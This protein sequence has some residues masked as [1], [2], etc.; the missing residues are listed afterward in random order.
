MS[1]PV[2]KKEE[3]KSRGP[4]TLNRK[5]QKNARKYAGTACNVC[6][7]LGFVYDPLGAGKSGGAYDLCECMKKVA[8]ATEPPYHYYDPES[9]SM[10]DCPTRPARDAMDRIRIL[11]RTSGIPDRYRGSFLSPIADSCE[12][13]AALIPVLAAVDH[14]VSSIVAFG[15]NRM[16][17][18]YFHG[19]TGTGKTM[20][21][22]AMLNE[23]IRLYQRHV[24]YAKISRDVLGPLRAS[25]NPNSDLY[26]EGRRIEQEL[27]S[28]PV[29]VIDDFGVQQDTEWAGGVLYDL[30][31]ARYGANLL[32]IFTSNEP[33]DAWKHISKGRLVSRLREMASEIHIDAPDY[34]MR[35]QRTY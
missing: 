16:E 21:A 6:D 27:A 23:I 4:V 26:G 7:G 31:D 30:V 2:I 15:E 33:M 35:S 28:I 32:T 8:R 1:L 24:K 10:L 29:L 5:L 17:G 20:L 9:N 25:F 11:L 19:P 22:C 18:L 3:T 34:R 14:A 12:R 13:D